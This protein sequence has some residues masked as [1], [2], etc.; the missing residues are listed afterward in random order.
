MTHTAPLQIERRSGKRTPGHYDLS[1][2]LKTAD[3][4]TL[5]RSILVDISTIGIGI[6]SL[7]YLQPESTVL[8]SL[9][10]E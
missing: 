5:V 7:D 1:G 9:K 4:Q 2:C 8:I 3:T 6:R 10:E